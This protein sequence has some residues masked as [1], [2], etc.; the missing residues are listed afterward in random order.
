MS[1]SLWL[2][3]QHSWDAIALFTFFFKQLYSFTTSSMTPEYQLLRETAFWKVLSMLKEVV[4]ALFFHSKFRDK[5]EEK[6]S[7]QTDCLCSP[8]Q[9]V[10]SQKYFLK[11]YQSKHSFSALFPCWNAVWVYLDQGSNSLLY[12]L[13]RNWQGWEINSNLS[14]VPGEAKAIL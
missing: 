11:A 6:C 13:L 2:I 3:L 9:K 12:F 8:V 4:V 5:K 14:R 7:T 10:H 1:S